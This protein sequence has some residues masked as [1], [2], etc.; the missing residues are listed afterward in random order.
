VVDNSALRVSDISGQTKPYVVPAVLPNGTVGTT[1]SATISA[2]GGNPASRHWLVS[3]GAL[4][5]GLLLAAS[6]GA[7][8]G[9]ITASTASLYSFGI[10]AT[11]TASGFASQTQPFS[12]VVTGGVSTIAV[13]VASAPAG[14]SVTVDGTSYTAPHSFNW[15]PGS[16]HT[17]SVLSPQGSGTRYVFTNWSDLGAQTHQVSPAANATYT[18]SFGT[19]YLLKTSV[20]P[21]GSGTVAA[22][23]ASADGY[24]NS[25]TTVK[26]TATPAAGF[27]FSGFSGNL[28]GSAN[29]Q[30]LAMSAP[31]SVTAN[32][33]APPAAPVLDSPKNGSTG[34]SRTPTL[35]WS[36]SSG[37]TSYD[38]Y[39]G[40]SSSPLFVKNTTGTSFNPGTLH[41][42]ATYYW[43]IVAK[44]SVGSTSSVTWS[45]TTKH[46][47]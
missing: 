47:W 20:S 17:L 31:L 46:G 30:S 23:P 21:T 22:S 44:N 36:A 4:P 41:A 40:S 7:I 32:F 33:A 35:R 3:S 14:R 26:L 1:Y 12:I 19:Q 6:T 25:G 11:D 2:V 45:F 15:V 28:T 27:V 29:P 16:S 13:T 10:T 43:R 9:T 8:S 34:D 42:G 39:F 18:A 24:Y 37:A 38:V 5:P